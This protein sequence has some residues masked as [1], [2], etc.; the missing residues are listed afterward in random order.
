MQCGTGAVSLP[1]PNEDATNQFAM[2]MVNMMNE[3]AAALMVSIGHQTGLFDAMERIGPADSHEIAQ[4]AGMNERYVRE[5]LGAMT[6]SEI[7]SFH[8]ESGKYELPVEHAKS[9]TRAAGADNIAVLSQY[10]PMMATVEQKIVHCFKQGGGVPYSEYDRFQSIMAEDSAQ[11]VSS[12]LVDS[13]LPLADGIIERLQKGIQVLDVGCGKGLALIEMAK[14]FPNSQFKGYEISEEGVDFGNQYALEQK[15]SNLLFVKQDAS[16]MNEAEAYDLITTF[17]SVHDQ[18]KPQEV[19][20]NIYR[21]LKPEGVYLMQDIDASSNVDKN[22]D[23][24]IGTLLYTI[25][26]MHC[27]TVSLAEGGAGLGAVWGVELAQV[28]LKE[29][30]FRFTEIKRL[31]HDFQNCYY[32]NQK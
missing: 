21:A 23:H 20:D 6:T 27:M 24:P 26:C 16:L 32:I 14:R 8:P 9:L 12:S 7:I 10:I 2:R 17:D 4:A 25:S 13:I 18:A 3:G 31:E 19:L 5:W 11:T 15:R 22:I 28:M 30:G 29:A 1:Q